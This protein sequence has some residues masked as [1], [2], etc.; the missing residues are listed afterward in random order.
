MLVIAAALG[1]AL[2]WGTSAACD[3]RSTRLIGA[4]QALAWVQVFGFVMVLPMA[5]WEGSPSQPSASALAWIVVGGV[6][7]SA[8][9]TFSY[10]AIGRGAISV[11]APVTAIDGALAALASVALGEHIAIATAAGLAIVV[12]GM[13]VVLYA[14]A[15]QERAG[16]VGHSLA[17]VLL[18]GAAACGFGIFLLAVIRAG[19]AFGDGQLQLIYRVVP[20]AVV[21]LPLLLQG[22]LGWPGR[23]WT[24]VTAAAALQTAGFVLYRVAG[25]SG[26]VAI[27]SV[28]SSQ[29]AVFAIIGGVLLLGERLSRRQVGGLAGLLVG[30]AVIAGTHA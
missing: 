3:N 13:L 4:L 26:D 9:L 20:F 30:I 12:A 18:A 21:G 8:G 28:L 15:A 27:P 11:V 17:A 25:R 5:V 10:A 24:W 14:T 29:F 23:A 22:R 19:D 1:A 2:A 16:V 6:G 7:V